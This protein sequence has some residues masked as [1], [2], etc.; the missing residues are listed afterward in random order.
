MKEGG[1]ANP[2]SYTH[3]D[4]IKPTIMQA[5]PATWMALYLVGWRNKFRTKI[6][7]GGEALPIKLKDFFMKDQSEVWNMFCL[8]YT[9]RCV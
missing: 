9:S 4:Y 7:C 6:L 1:Y 2:V 3:L 5:T 8:L